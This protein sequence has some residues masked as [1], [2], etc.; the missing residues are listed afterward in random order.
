MIYLKN[1]IIGDGKTDYNDNIDLCF[2]FNARV[3]KLCEHYDKS[4]ELF[5]R[6][7][8]V[9]LGSRQN[10]TKHLLCAKLTHTLKAKQKREK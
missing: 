4:N 7:A 1:V 5:K 6:R 10:F 3:V 9:V 8:R 2:F